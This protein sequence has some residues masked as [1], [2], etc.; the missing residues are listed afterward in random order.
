MNSFRRGLKHP[1][2]SR[3]TK[4]H[5]YF[6]QAGEDGPIKIGFSKDPVSR[7]RTLQTAHT[8]KLKMLHHQTGTRVDEVKLHHKFK[9]LKIRGEWYQAKGPLLDFIQKRKTS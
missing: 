1:F 7:L 3:P 2:G 4:G 8:E 5:I 6:I 9:S